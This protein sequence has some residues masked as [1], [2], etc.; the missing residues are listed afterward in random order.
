[1]LSS[2]FK[3]QIYD[4]LQYIPQESNIGLFSATISEEILEITNRI[5]KKSP[6]NF[7]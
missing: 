7:S 5:M 3:E 1:M 2:G 6:K 4:I